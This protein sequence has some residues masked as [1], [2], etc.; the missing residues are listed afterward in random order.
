MSF[1]DDEVQEL[2]FPS[3]QRF[4]ASHREGGVSDS[5]RP[6]RFITRVCG[7]EVLAVDQDNVP[8]FSRYRLG[9]G[10]VFVLNFG[11]E[12]V[13]TINPG[14][15]EVGA[16]DYARFYRLFAAEALQ[17]RLLRKADHCRALA[18]TEHRVENNKVVCV[19]TNH[20]TQRLATV[21]DV[22]NQVRRI[23]PRIGGV[24][25]RDNGLEIDI[26]PFDGF[27]IEVDVAAD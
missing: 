15:F 4:S 2:T 7:A 19:G 5:S 24:S 14:A 22:N 13:L 1:C 25:E 11:M 3:E 26:E 27:V 8:M 6:F 21:L 18:L 23:K 20:S 16:D 12:M 9:R 17:G 10:Q